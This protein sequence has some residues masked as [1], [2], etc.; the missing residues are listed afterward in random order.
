MV[1]R[2]LSRGRTAE[3]ET[4]RSAGLTHDKHRAIRQAL[5]L[6]F[7]DTVKAVTCCNS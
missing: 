7:L 1:I 6:C 3:G 5:E 2:K 4:A